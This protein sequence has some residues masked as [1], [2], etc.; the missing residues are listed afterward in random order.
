M[1]HPIDDPAAGE[2]VRMETRGF[3]RVITINRPQRANA[4]TDEVAKRLAEAFVEAHF[5]NEVRAIVITGTGDRA[6]CS[7]ADMKDVLN[8]QQANNSRARGLF[9]SVMRNLYEVILNTYKPTIAALNGAAVAGGFEVA[10]ACDL[11][12]AGEH[13][14]LGVPE[15]KRGMGAHFASIMLP[16]IV[17]MSIAYEMLYTGEPITAQDAH[18]WG[19]V[20]QLTRKGEELAQALALA[21]R[22]A[23]NAPITLR[24]MKETLI[25]SSGM[26]ISAAL[27]LNEGISP[28]E[29][30]DRLEG[31][32]A[33]VE[34][35]KPNWKNR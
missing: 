16:R 29:S 19:L 15:A 2:E 32:R 12:I 31:F 8:R 27:H 5:D 4:M 21:E 20:T 11:R 1:S 35:R 28:Y 22:L 24:R 30:E 34:K 3:T 18:R 6:F 23:Q 9:G 26:P 33:F 14:V 17:P 25:K 10:I 7:G 13:V